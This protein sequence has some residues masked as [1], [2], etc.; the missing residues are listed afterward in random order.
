VTNTLA[1]YGTES[2]TAAKKVSMR[3]QWPV[4]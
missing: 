2:I 3:P 1:Y 4:L